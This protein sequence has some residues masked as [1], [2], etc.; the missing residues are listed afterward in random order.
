MIRGTSLFVLISLAL[1]HQK[2]FINQQ[3]VFCFF[4]TV[5]DGD[6]RVETG[7]HVTS[8]QQRTEHCCLQVDYEKVCHE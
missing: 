6:G 1:F 5:V 4:T 8:Q 2:W 7:I 3:V